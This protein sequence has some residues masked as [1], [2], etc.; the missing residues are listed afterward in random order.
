MSKHTLLQTFAV[1]TALA[2]TALPALAQEGPYEPGLYIGAEGGLTDLSNQDINSRLG[3]I[4]RDNKSLGGNLAA[5]V[6]Y[7]ADTWRVEASARFRWN[8]YGTFVTTNSAAANLVPG[9]YSVDGLQHSQTYGLSFLVNL[10]DFDEWQLFAD[11]GAGATHL[12]VRN[13]AISDTGVIVANDSPWTVT[14]H[15]GA[16]LIK[17]IGNGF[18]F[19]FGYRYFHSADADLQTR[20]GIAE[21]GHNG[22]DL[23]AKLTYRFGGDNRRRAVEPAPAPRPEPVA[24]PAPAP[25]PTPA[26][27]E[28]PAPAP[29]PAPEPAPLP[30]PFLVFFDFDSS[31]ITSSAS[32]IIDAAARAYL[33]GEDIQIAA[34]GHTDSSGA[35]GYNQSLSERR[36]AAVRQALIAAGVSAEDIETAARGES[37][38]LVSTDDGVREPQNRRVEIVLDRD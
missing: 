18:E 24:A 5:I 30:G 10:V 7:D 2:S 3:L 35:A 9:L 20:Q 28:E 11:V 22:H 21:Y 38:P 36:A 31:T 37:D 32:R 34:T 14:G 29:A 12:K 4:G 17:P 19:G 26:V 27:V 1:T 25:T 8:D 33:N 23:F 16:Q 13:L 6:G 15:I